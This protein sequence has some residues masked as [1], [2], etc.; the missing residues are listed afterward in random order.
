MTYD[1][2]CEISVTYGNHT[3]NTTAPG[4][5]VLA[6]ERTVTG[7]EILNPYIEVVDNKVNVTLTW[8][9]KFSDNTKTEESV[10]EFFDRHR[11]RKR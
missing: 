10:S 8:V 4:K 6:K 2:S 5:I 1:Y 9:T 11:C 7:H 3:Q